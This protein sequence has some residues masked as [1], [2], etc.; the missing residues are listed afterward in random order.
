MYSYVINVGSEDIY[1]TDS[2]NSKNFHP[3][4]NPSSMISSIL[5]WDIGFN[6]VSR[7]HGTALHLCVRLCM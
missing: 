7:D 1:F 5:V 3:C 4:S 6:W 2:P